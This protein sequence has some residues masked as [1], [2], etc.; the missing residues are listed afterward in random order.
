MEIKHRENDSRGIFF[1]ENEKG[2]FAELTYTKGAN[3][4]LTI[5]HTEVHPSREN[6]GIATKLVKKTV[7]Y[8]RE[9]DYKINPLCPFAEV[10]F[11]RNPSYEDVR[12]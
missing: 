5:D 8:A 2:V 10:Q 6:E 12:A 4:V 9:K 1:I 7:E 3:G 11:E